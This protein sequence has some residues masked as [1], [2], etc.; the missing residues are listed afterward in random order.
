VPSDKL[1]RK[2]K[3]EAGEILMDKLSGGR[4]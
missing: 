1:L 2:L 3:I 4:A